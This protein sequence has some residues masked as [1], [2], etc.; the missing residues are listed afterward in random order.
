MCGTALRIS[1]FVAIVAC[2][3]M[4]AAGTRAQSTPLLADSCQAAL[5]AQACAN[6]ASAGVAPAAASGLYVAL[7]QSSKTYSVGV[8]HGQPS[9]A[10]AEQAALAECKS[11]GANDC[12]ILW[13]GQN[14]CVAY[15]INQTRTAV[16]TRTTMGMGYDP[17]RA[18]AAAEAIQHCTSD[19]GTQCTILA[20]TCANDDLRWPSPLP[21][22]SS[23]TPG[24]VDPGLVGV[25][26]I[27]VPGGRWV[28]Q[29]TANGGY[30]FHSEAMDGVASNIG[31][32]AAA[33]G[34]YTLHATNLAWDDTGIYTI[35]SSSSFVGTG[36]LGTGTWTR[37][38]SDDE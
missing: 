28:W 7:A 25:W 3:L 10:G 18:F 33:S 29:I 37:I 21:L 20:A 14:S 17:I 1:V 11:T 5:G 36:K 38:A 23:G 26:T 27:A 30:E 32:F 8:A 15:A 16:Y 31:T 24:S 9:K 6:L 35:N 34:R 13:S 22:P 4:N 19:A 12:K 2:T